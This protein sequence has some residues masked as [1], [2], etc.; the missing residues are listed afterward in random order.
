MQETWVR[1]L[2]WE[3]PTRHEATKAV[4]HNYWACAL[5]PGSRNCGAHA[6]SHHGPRALEPCYPTSETTA[7]RR[8]TLQLEGSPCWPQPEESPRSNKDPAQ[9]N[10]QVIFFFC[11]NV[12]LS[13]HK[14]VNIIYYINKLKNHTIILR[15][16][17][18]Q[19]P[20]SSDKTS[21]QMK[22]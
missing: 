10:D 1:F 19:N 15:D 20:M 8:L 18:K 6:L 17:E 7:T 11:K 13:T 4:H 22:L 16:M 12:R 3:D 2:I 9:P 5:E 21:Q 14:P